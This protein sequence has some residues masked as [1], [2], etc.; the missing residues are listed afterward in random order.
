[1]TWLE[2]TSQSR[3]LAIALL[4]GALGIMSAVLGH[5]LRERAAYHVQLVVIHSQTRTY[6]QLINDAPLRTQVAARIEAMLRR[7]S[8]VIEGGNANP[9]ERA[10]EL[11]LRALLDRSGIGSPRLETEFRQ[12]GEDDIGLVTAHVTAECP[13]AELVRAM[14]AV[15]QERPHL[16]V[17]RLRID[18]DQMGQALL[19]GPHML[20]VSFSIVGVV[21]MP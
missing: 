15:Q 7:D 9:T 3:L 4:V 5:M 19:P 16:F 10:F 17:N 2:L 12:A 8:S 18:S 1:M 14:H 21:R 20:H 6:E 11:R 13:I